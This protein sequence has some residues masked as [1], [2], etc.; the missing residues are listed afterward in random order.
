VH[1]GAE[2]VDDGDYDAGGMSVDGNRGRG[3]AHDRGRTER[4]RVGFCPLPRDGQL[5]RAARRA[6]AGAVADADGGAER[7]GVP[8]RL[9]LRRSAIS[10]PAAGGSTNFDVFQQSV[11]NTC[12]GPLQNACVW[13][14]EADVSWIAITTPMPTAGDN[15]VNFTAAPNTTGVARTGTIRVRDKTVTVTQPGS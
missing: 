11:P 6:G 2:R 1:V 13:S 3:V 5:G 10:V 4:I 7:Q 14:A 15:R 12:G 9:P 8:G